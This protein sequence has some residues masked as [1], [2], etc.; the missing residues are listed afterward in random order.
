M[1]GQLISGGE[2]IGDY[3]NLTGASKDAM[4][5][6]GKLL[7]DNQAT[8]EPETGN[9]NLDEILR[10]LPQYGADNYTDEVATFT[11]MI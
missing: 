7:Y 9:Y 3:L 5:A 2:D 10:I 8:I 11:R 1:I 4:D 6:I